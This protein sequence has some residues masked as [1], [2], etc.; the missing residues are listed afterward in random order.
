MAGL[1]SLPADYVNLALNSDAGSGNK[2]V[3]VD[4]GGA[5]GRKIVVRS[6]ERFAGLVISNLAK[7]K[8][9]KLKIHINEAVIATLSPAFSALAG[10]PSLSLLALKAATFEDAAAVA[11]FAEL[12]VSSNIPASCVISLPKKVETSAGA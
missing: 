1:L 5:D 3:I 9:L 8:M 12:I 11:A 6:P 7:I 2:L 10:A 4:D